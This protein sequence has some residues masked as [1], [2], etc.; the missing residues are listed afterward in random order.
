MKPLRSK[1]MERTFVV[2]I[3]LAG[4]R[5]RRLQSASLR[6]SMI[7]VPRVH[8]STIASGAVRL[9]VWPVVEV[10]HFGVASL[11]SGAT[12]VGFTVME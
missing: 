3:Q 4:A 7:R 11:A 8:F 12:P 1:R 5:T 2:E 6:L 10:V 9:S